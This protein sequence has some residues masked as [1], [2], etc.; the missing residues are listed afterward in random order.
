[1]REAR[2]HKSTHNETE[3]H[4]L[5]RIHLRVLLI[6]QS[7]PNNL[8]AMS[9]VGYTQLQ[10]LVDRAHIEDTLVQL[11]WSLDRQDWDLERAILN[12]EGVSFDASTLVGPRPNF[13][14]VISVED[15]IKGDVQ[16]SSCLDT[17]HNAI[18]LMRHNL[19]LPGSQVARPEEAATEL[20]VT[21]HITNKSAKDGELVAYGGY[22]NVLLK[23]SPAEEN[24]N[25]WKVTTLKLNKMWLDGNYKALF[26]SG[27]Q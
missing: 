5:S 11:F 20:N 21:T 1:M 8:I 10:W 23:R 25:P 17:N 24:A 3:D 7:S 19:P 9:E 4:R 2:Q 18:S 13:G 22:Y 6:L 15:H 27:G 16:L 12:P 26:P 14:K